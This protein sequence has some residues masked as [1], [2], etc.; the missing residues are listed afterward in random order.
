MKNISKHWLLIPAGLSIGIMFV[1]KP[2]TWAVTV[3]GWSTIIFSV[4]W[5]ALVLRDNKFVKR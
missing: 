3:T 4:W 1:I 5:F 2:G